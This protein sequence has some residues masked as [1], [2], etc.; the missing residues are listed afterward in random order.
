[1]N[2]FSK[3]HCSGQRQGLRS[4]EERSLLG[5]NEHRRNERNEVFAI[6]SI[7]ARQRQGLRSCEERSLLGVNE[8]RRNERNEVFARYNAF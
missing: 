5:V 6:K 8:H 2:H 4:Y 7:V 3:K 1:M